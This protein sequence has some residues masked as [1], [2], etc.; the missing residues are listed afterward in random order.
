MRN[1]LLAFLAGSLITATAVIFADTRTGWMFIAGVICCLIL[2]TAL[3]CSVAHA[4][5]LARFLD[6]VC[7]SMESVK[8]IRPASRNPRATPVLTE[9]ASDPRITDL[10]SA[11]VNCGMGRTKA[12]A[13]AQQAAEAGGS[14]EDMFRRATARPN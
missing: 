8:T 2:Q 10:T 6:G 9:T 14:F 5:V 13:I 1:I 4:R 7:D 3:L 12:A 11:L